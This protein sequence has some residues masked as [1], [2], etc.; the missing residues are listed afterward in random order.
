MISPAGDS[1]P[2]IPM[3]KQEL[4][5]PLLKDMFLIRAGCVILRALQNL[6]GALPVEHEVKHGSPLNPHAGE[7]VLLITARDFTLQLVGGGF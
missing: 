5:C 2:C 6:R 3:I 4:F 1:L 7:D